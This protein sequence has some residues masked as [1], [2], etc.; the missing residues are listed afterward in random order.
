M[1]RWRSFVAARDMRSP[2]SLLPS[3]RKCTVTASLPSFFD[4]FLLRRSWSRK[5]YDWKAKSRL[6]HQFPISL[7]RN[8]DFS[9]PQETA[10]V[11][12]VQ[13]RVE[14]TSISPPLT[15]MVGVQAGQFATKSGQAY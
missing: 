15:Q 14:F 7:Y 10:S 3:C 11:A 9:A 8:R 4:T 1:V 6:D 2:D 13:P 12:T 5:G